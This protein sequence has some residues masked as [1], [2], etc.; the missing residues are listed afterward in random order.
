MIK[1]KQGTVNTSKADIFIV[2]SNNFYSRYYCINVTKR[3]FQQKRIQL[4]GRI[5]LSS[6]FKPQINIILKHK[7]KT[8]EDTRRNQR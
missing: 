4:T 3:A 1:I 6:F 2:I 8:V 7:D 5:L